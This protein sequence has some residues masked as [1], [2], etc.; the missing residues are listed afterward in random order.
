M[1]NIPRIYLNENLE[2]GKS[3]PISKDIAHYLKDVMRTDKCLV[4]NN[5]EEFEAELVPDSRFLVPTSKTG[6]PDP[7][8]ELTLAFAP[9]KQARLEEMLSMATQ[10][11]VAR[12]QPVVT[13]RVNEHHVKWDRIRKIIIEAAEQSGRNSVPELMEPM[14]FDAFLEGTGDLVFADERLANPHPRVSSSLTLARNS[15]P[16]RKRGRKSPGTILIGPEGGFSEKEFA[17]LDVAGAAGIS[18]GKT[19]LRA[20]TAAVAAIAKIVASR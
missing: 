19:I 8:N 4:F 3:F 10:M 7:S 11:G 18:L 16:P 6:R 20:E 1:R 14:E 17:A 13:D 12:L 15:I 2:V 5:G 9:I